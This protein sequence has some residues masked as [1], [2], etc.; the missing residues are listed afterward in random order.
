MK[1]IN[2]LNNNIT[3]ISLF[4]NLIVIIDLIK[5]ALDFVF[6]KYYIKKV[7]G[8]NNEF[9]N[10]SCYD[11][12]NNFLSYHDIEAV[13]NIITM[14]FEINQKFTFTRI[15][16]DVDNEMCIGGFLVNRKINTYF[17]KYFEDFKYLMLP[18]L[19]ERYG[20]NPFIEYNPDENGYKV[21][22]IVLSCDSSTDYAFLIKL[23][24]EDLQ[25]AK[26]VIHIIHG[27]YE[28]GLI[29]ASEYLVTHYKEIYKEYKNRHYFFALEINR[30]D[31]SINHSKGRID[32]TDKMFN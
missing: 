4:L 6:K 21:R 8:Y 19:K 7:L 27:S 12:K 9:V 10:I 26:K 18:N 25:S 29:R 24:K 3:V 2:F 20:D 17:V 22:D 32:F 28:V 11:E 5:K 30:F 31:G 16:K 1:Y 13:N 14:F 15:D 23:T